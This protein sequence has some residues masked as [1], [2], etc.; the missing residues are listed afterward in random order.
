MS[1]PRRRVRLRMTPRDATDSPE[2]LSI[3][4]QAFQDSD[5]EI[6]LNETSSYETE[7]VEEDIVLSGEAV[8]TTKNTLELQN[9]AV[10]EGMTTVDSPDKSLRKVKDFVKTIRQESIKITVQTVLRE[11]LERA[12]DFL[13]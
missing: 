6:D 11:I 13:T 9:R 3:V 5:I 7:Q 2:F 1:P 12:K 10:T 8:E 4:A